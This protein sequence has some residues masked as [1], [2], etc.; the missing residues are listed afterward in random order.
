M[1]EFCK[2]RALLV[3]RVQNDCTLVD[4]AQAF[5]LVYNYNGGKS[6]E[7]VDRLRRHYIADISQEV[8]YC[9]HGFWKLA[10]DSGRA[11]RKPV[12]LKMREGFEYEKIEILTGGAVSH[13]EDETSC[14][15]CLS[16]L[17]NNT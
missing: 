2:E 3:T 11:N 4:N 16:T 15:T 12:V 6:K 1:R 13:G 9:N 7:Q 10:V 14:F 5:E 17:E 8:H